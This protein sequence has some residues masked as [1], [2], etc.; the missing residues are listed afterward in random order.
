MFVF[1]YNFVS[2][3]HSP[4]HSNWIF[5]GVSKLKNF[6]LLFSSFRFLTVWQA[7]ELSKKMLDL[8][9]WETR[10][11][12]TRNLLTAFAFICNHLIHNWQRQYD[13][14]GRRKESNCDQA[15][16]LLEAAQGSAMDMLRVVLLGHWQVGKLILW[17][18]YFVNWFDWDRCIWIGSYLSR[19]TIFRCASNSRSRGSKRSS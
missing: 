10:F 17:T 6:T 12:L 1:C 19:R 8:F 9:Y 14:Y 5:L 7:I 18:F 15:V 4:L 3:L 16:K 2:L 13:N 11:D